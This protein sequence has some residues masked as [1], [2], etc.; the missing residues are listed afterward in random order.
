MTFNRSVRSYI[1]WRTKSNISA[2]VS[3]QILLHKIGMEEIRVTHSHTVIYES[4][5]VTQSHTS[6][7]QSHSHIR[8]TSVTYSHFFVA[9]SSLHLISMQENSFSYVFKRDRTKENSFSS[10]WITSY[11][12]RTAKK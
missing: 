8:V 9:L 1:D 6:H 2:T 7:S 10:A 12:D 11:N 4:L 3:T 5:T